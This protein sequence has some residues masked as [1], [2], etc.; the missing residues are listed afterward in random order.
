VPELVY[1]RRHVHQMFNNYDQHDVVE[2]AEHFLQAARRAELGAFRC[3]RWDHVTLPDAWRVATHV[4]RLFG[5][6]DEQRSQ[7]SCCGHAQRRFTAG[8]IVKLGL[9]ADRNVASGVS[10]LYLAGCAAETRDLDCEGEVCAGARVP[11]LLQRRVSTL[12]NV[13]LVQVQRSLSVD[14]A[15]SRHVVYPEEKLSLRGLGDLE[16]AGVV[17]HHG[18]R[19]NTGHYTCACRGQDDRFYYYDDSKQ[20]QRVAGE[21]SSVLPRNAVLL[22]YIR[23]RGRADFSGSATSIA[24]PSVEAPSGSGGPAD[25]RVV[26]DLESGPAAPAPEVGICSTRRLL[27]KTTSAASDPGVPPVSPLAAAA[28]PLRRLSRKTSHASDAGP[29]GAATPDMVDAAVS[30]VPPDIAAQF[31]PSVVDARCCLGRTKEGTQCLQARVLDSDLCRRHQKDKAPY[32]LVTGE[33]PVGKLEHFVA[34]ARSRAKAIARSVQAAAAVSQRE[35]SKRASADA[36]VR[37]EGSRLKRRRAGG[38]ETLSLLGDRAAGGQSSDRRA[39]I[40]SGFGAERVEDVAADEARRIAEGAMRGELRREEGTR[41][42]MRD[43]DN[44]DLDRSAGGAWHLGR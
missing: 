4:D 14:G 21:I 1:R 42:R 2:F 18:A 43:F 44:Q 15:P 16:L 25:A 6:V 7:C 30:T 11:H 36:A 10:D 20:A 26:I 22:A 31:T 13:L 41:G 34:L 19:A 28:S 29:G 38:Q 5:F 24:G 39:R 27:R 12:P 3:G 8:M 9:P 35:A 32:G 17:Y 40:V 23:Q 33:V 37:L